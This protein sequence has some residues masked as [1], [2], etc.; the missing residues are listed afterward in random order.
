MD[1]HL[2]DD[3]A[4]L[5][6]VARFP[7]AVAYR[8]NFEELLLTYLDLPARRDRTGRRDGRRAAMRRALDNRATYTQIRDWRQGYRPAPIWAWDLLENKIEKRQAA[9]ARAKAKRPAINRPLAS[10]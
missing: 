4:Q 5:K 3:R 2:K 8:S 6:H 1:E 9:Y 7:A 10:C